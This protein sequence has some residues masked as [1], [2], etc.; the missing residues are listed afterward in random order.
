MIW[1]ALETHLFIVFYYLYVALLQD[2][3]KFSL[4]GGILLV[5]Y[6]CYLKK[7]AHCLTSIFKEPEMLMVKYMCVYVSRGFG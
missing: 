1:K 7:R 2:Q 4:C 6:I 3:Y 5:Q